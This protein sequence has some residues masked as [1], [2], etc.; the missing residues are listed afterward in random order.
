MRKFCT[1]RPNF[2]NCR[3]WQTAAASTLR[4]PFMPN[5]LR[6]GGPRTQLLEQRLFARIDQ[7]GQPGGALFDGQVELTSSDMAMCMT[8]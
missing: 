7:D 5:A 3:S 2:V 8:L 1:G 6:L 4:A